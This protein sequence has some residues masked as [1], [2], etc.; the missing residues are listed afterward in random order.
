MD[1]ACTIRY[2]SNSFHRV[3]AVPWPATGRI[4]E[5]GP[6]LAGL[7]E[8]NSDGSAWDGWEDGMSHPPPVSSVPF[9]THLASRRL[10]LSR[11]GNKKEKR[12]QNEVDEQQ[13]SAFEPISFSVAGYLKY[14]N[15]GD[16]NRDDLG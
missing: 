11:L 3:A 8:R 1:S 7:K 5:S 2:F 12:S 14:D 4:I 13:L 6:K 15:D 16:E 10:D 9:S